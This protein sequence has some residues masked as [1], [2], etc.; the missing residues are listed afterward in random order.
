MELEV[1]RFSSQR[2]STLGLF[3]NITTDRNFLCFT[4]EDEFRAVK[5][6][7]E[8]RISAGR[9]EIKLRTEGGFNQRYAKKFPKMHKGM[10]H[11]TNVPGFTFVLIH[12]GNNDDD[13][14]A[15]LLVGNSAEQNI[16]KKG[17]TGGSTGAYK[18]IYPLIS[19]ALTSGEKVF[20]NFIDFG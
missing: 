17:F 5:K 6:Y 19:K 2:D 20:I 1:L 15:C 9:H 3:F 10:L 16:T 7:G 4:L 11:I 14:D 12:I 8:T 13:T 18:R